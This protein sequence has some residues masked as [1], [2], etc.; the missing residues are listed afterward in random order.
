VGLSVCRANTEAHGV[1][2]GGLGE[3]GEGVLLSFNASPDLEKRSM[4]P[5]P[6]APESALRRATPN[7]SF[8]TPVPPGLNAV[9]R[10]L[11]PSSRG[12]GHLLSGG[13]RGDPLGGIQSKSEAF[14]L[15]FDDNHA[16]NAIRCLQ[17]L[18]NHRAV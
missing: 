10:G 12:L 7:R 5:G 9:P 6:L 17:R 1:A 13:D 4:G 11:A 18:R 2:V 14:L 15:T 16:I 3:P 8:P